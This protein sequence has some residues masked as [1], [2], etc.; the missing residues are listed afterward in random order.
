[1]RGILAIIL[2]GVVIVALYL[3]LV[4]RGI[5]PPPLLTYAYDMIVSDRV[6][7][8][9]VAFAIGFVS[10]TVITSHRR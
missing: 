5:T 1:M 9:L 7:I 2:V 3:T 8:F 4:G 10:A 6:I